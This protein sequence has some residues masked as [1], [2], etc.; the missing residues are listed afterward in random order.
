MTMRRL[1]VL[2]SVLAALVVAGCGSST[3]TVTTTNAQGKQ[4]TQTVPDIKFAKTKF[5]VHSGLAFGAF[6]RYILKPYRAGSFKKGAPG[7]TKSLAKAGAAGLFAVHE[8]K[9]A[10]KDALADDH[11]RPLAN[12]LDAAVGRLGSL[13]SVLKGGGLN[14]GGLLGAAG[15]ITALGRQSAGAGA[16]IKDRAA[17]GLGG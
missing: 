17:P 1:L 11:L 15:A 10:R 8:L 9:V 13:S 12:R 6:H 14:P 7:R 3:K 16:T 5:L 4:V 2:C